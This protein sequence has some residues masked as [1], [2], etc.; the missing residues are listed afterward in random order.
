MHL[1]LFSR[2][3]LGGTLTFL[4]ACLPLSAQTNAGAALAELQHVMFGNL[5]IQKIVLSGQVVWTVG[6]SQDSGQVSLTADVTGN[7]VSDFILAKS[8]EH[9]DVVEAGP[10]SACTLSVPGQSTHTANGLSCW[11][12]TA[13][14]YPAISLQ[15]TSLL[16]GIGIVDLGTGEVGSGTYRHLQSQLVLSAL[17]SSL[18][19]RLM[20]D[21]TTDIGLDP[22]SFLPAVLRYSVHPDDGSAALIPIEI[23][24]S[25]YQQV[26]G[27]QVPYLIEKYV[28]GALLASITVTSTQIN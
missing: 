26:N 16:S 28:N 5:P 20:T 15:P 8:G 27:V 21:S 6:S 13:W 18:T 3:L 7:V 2:I 12:P 1:G 22:S 10:L 25:N 4:I 11:R 14:F 23:H 24:F 19:M 17:E 9:K